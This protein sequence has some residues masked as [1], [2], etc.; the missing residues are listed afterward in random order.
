MEQEFLVVSREDM[1][2]RDWHYL[3]YII[4]SGDA[5]VDHP[6]FGAAV[7]GRLLESR[8]FRVGVIAQPDWRKKESFEVIGRPRYAF[9]ITAGNLDSMVSNYTASKRKRT[10]DEYSPEGKR[11]LRPDR[12]TIVYANRVREAFP[13]VPIILGGIEASLRRLAHYDYWDDRVRRSILVDAAADL[14]IYGMGELQILEVAQRL[15][16]GEALEEMRD[17]KG[18]VFATKE[19]PIKGMPFSA[20]KLPSFTEVV[21]KKQKYA[22]AFKVQYLNQHTH[23]GRAL[24][25]E[26]DSL[27]VVQTPPA[28][29]LTQDE[30]NEIYDLPFL[31]TFHPMY[32]NA[33]GVPALQEVEFSV[34]SHRGCFGGCAFCALN[35]HQ[36]RIIQARSEESILKE[37]RRMT[38]SP[39]FKGI[40]HDIG[41]PTANFRKPACR[42][43]GCTDRLCLH[44]KRCKNLQVN[45]DEY[46]RLLRKARKIPGVKKVFVRSGVR[47]DYLMAD[48]KK[49]DLVKEL[50]E[51]HISGLLKVAPEH[52]AEGVTSLMRKPSKRVFEGFKNLFY[53]TNEALGKKQYLVPYFITSHPGTTLKDAVELAEYVRDLGYNPEQVQDFTPTPGSL[54]TAM[55][56]TGV[57]P[58]TGKKV[59]IPKNIEERKMQRALL[60]YRNPK[61]RELVR[62]ALKITGREDLIGYG[63]KALVPPAKTKGAGNQG[64]AKGKRR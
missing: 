3:D 2:A 51:H 14:L 22:E 20:Q 44:P 31:R 25:Q 40:V 34:T 61:N 37:I 46:I 9:L 59:Y 58:L 16:K 32:K 6:S 39:N 5:Y 35:F 48:P 19:I 21:K 11:G 18:T 54:A 10:T 15:K 56:Y 55:Y 45:H 63:P 41:G 53:K 23:L 8:G 52:V 64:K 29:P 57:D 26:H 27:Y 47:F 12:A 50:C 36:G 38:E 33:G 28:R 17:I 24:I 1:A 30:M 49:R 60:Q 42:G 43:K 7:I 13:E 62:K 4:I